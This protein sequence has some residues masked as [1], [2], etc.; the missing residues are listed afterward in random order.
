[1]NTIKDTFIGRLAIFEIDCF[2]SFSDGYSLKII[3]KTEDIDLF[4]LKCK[5][6]SGSLSSLDWIYGVDDWGFDVAFLLS[7]YQLPMA[8]HEGCLTLIVDIILRT[9][10]SKDADGKYLYDYNDLHG[11]TAIDFTGNAVDSILSP[12]IAIKKVNVASQCIEWLPPQVYA[13][14][15]STTLNGTKCNLIFTV[16]VDRNDLSVDT[17]DLG[18]S[19]SVVRLEFNERQSLS[20]I[21]ICWQAVCTLLAFCVGQYNITDTNIGLWDK[22]QSIGIAGFR[23]QIDCAI[24]T[25]KVEGVKFQYPAFYRFQI[26]YLGEKLGKLFELL[27]CENTR[28]ILDFLPRTNSDN[29]V[30]KNKI[31]ELCTALEVE[32]NYL[33]K[34]TANP[35]V[36]TLV[37]NLKRQ[38]KAFRKE[39]PDILNGSTYDYIYGTLK[40][41]SLPAKEK[42]WRVYRK[43]AAIIDK[44]TKQANRFIINN[45]ETQTL[46]DIGWLVNLRNSLTHSTKFTEDEIPNAIYFR[47][48]IAVYCSVFESSGYSLEEIS[49]IIKRYFRYII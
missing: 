32:F 17:T 2:F 33:N 39:N 20:M 9:S 24:N 18:K 22:N 3:P 25:E 48:K 30:D 21:K 12:K 27:N 19:Y 1:M 47:L 35:A 46:K 29:G 5:E 4:R 14:I 10:N 26:N 6:T 7:E 11:F 38:V 41:I 31:R 34:E 16:V 36:T 37:D 8:Y 40:H 49:D 42:L 28:P 43:Y 13:K 15:F 23:S 45:S 44:E